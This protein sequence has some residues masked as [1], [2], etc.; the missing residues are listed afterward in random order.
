MAVAQNTRYSNIRSRAR[1][2]RGEWK[3]L[4]PRLELTRRPARENADLRC[5]AQHIVRVVF[6]KRNGLR[7]HATGK[8]PGNRRGAAVDRGT[9]GDLIA[10]EGIVRPS[11]GARASVPEIDRRVNAPRQTRLVRFAACTVLA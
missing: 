9:D 3:S 1:S 10:I 5:P 6:G 4:A 8:R 7:K 11:V 2:G